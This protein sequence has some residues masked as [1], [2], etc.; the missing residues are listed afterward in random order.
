MRS[1]RWSR[2]GSGAGS[3]SGTADEQ[4][5]KLGKQIAQWIKTRY[6]EQAR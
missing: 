1:R 2:P 5:A 6:F 3:T 4:G